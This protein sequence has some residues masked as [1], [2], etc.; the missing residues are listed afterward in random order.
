MR[1]ERGI[2]KLS[3]GACVCD[4]KRSDKEPSNQNACSIILEVGIWQEDFP[5]TNP[6]W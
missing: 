3:P 5:S 1:L 6:I 4:R 2:R